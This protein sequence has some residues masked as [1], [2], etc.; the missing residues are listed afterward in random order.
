MF[1][2]VMLI[3][4]LAAGLSQL[5]PEEPK[6]KQPARRRQP[7]PKP[8]AGQAESRKQAKRQAT[9][10]DLLILTPFGNRHY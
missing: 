4:F 8:Q 2:I 10:K 7:A 1:E 5:L 6:E 3:G 9:R